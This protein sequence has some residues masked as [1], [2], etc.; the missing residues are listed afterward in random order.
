ACVLKGLVL[1]QGLNAERP[2]SQPAGAV[3]NGSETIMD[4]NLAARGIWWTTLKRA[5][6]SKPP[7]LGSSQKT[8]G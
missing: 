7:R 4:P 5:Y 1:D 6:T 8:R 3:L 2:G